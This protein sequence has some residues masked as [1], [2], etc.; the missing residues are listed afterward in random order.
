MDIAIVGAGVSVTLDASGACTAAR[1]VLGAVAATPLRVDDAAA[2]LVGTVVDD[3]ALTAASAAASSAARP[4]D[5]KRGTVAYRKRVAGV[6]T[7]RAAAIA[8]DRANG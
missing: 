6:L 8:R 3:E 5:D 2:A 4:I 1:V 7:R